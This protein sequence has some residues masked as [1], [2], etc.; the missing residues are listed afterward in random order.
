MA[1]VKD[2]KEKTLGE[3]FGD[4]TRETS[5]L[6]RQEV[7]L[8]KTEMTQKAAKIGKNLG[9][10]VAGAVFGLGAFMAFVAFLILAIGLFVKLWLAALIVTLLLGAL[11]AVLALKG[12]AAI[13]S[14]SVVPQQTVETLKEDVQWA[15]EQAK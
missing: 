5:T 9:F 10:A 1:E 7:Q 4:L 12:I 3:L 6:V 13:K 11:A 2:P 15:K 8:A 14:V